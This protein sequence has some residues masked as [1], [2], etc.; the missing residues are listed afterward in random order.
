MPASWRGSP[1]TVNGGD[2]LLPKSAL[3]T[4]YRPRARATVE[5]PCRLTL[6]WVRWNA[7]PPCAAAQFQEGELSRVA[8]HGYEAAAVQQQPVAAG[9]G[10]AQDLVDRLDR[11]AIVAQLDPEELAAVRIHDDEPPVALGDNPVHVE[12]ARPGLVRDRAHVEC[13]R[14]AVPSL[15]L[16]G[17]HVPQ[18]RPER[19]GHEH[20][21]APGHH[22]VVQ[23][24]AHAGLEGRHRLLGGE[25]VHGDRSARPPAT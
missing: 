14:G 6:V 7:S 12:L 10:G 15:H 9:H 8:L 25:V 1:A 23:E 16:R 17:G 11:R 22:D 4:R 20:V 18:R 3:T 21:A 5:D 24:A 19:V 2:T 13:L